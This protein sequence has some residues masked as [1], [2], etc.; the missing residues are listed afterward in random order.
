MQKIKEFS[1]CRITVADNGRIWI[2]GEDK[3]I[4]HVREFCHS[5]TRNSNLN[6]SETNKLLENKNS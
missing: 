4:L 1:G 3:G 2:E 6:H 5:L